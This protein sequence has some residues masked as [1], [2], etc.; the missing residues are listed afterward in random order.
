MYV[1]WNF[2]KDGR[3]QTGQKMKAITINW[4]RIKHVKPPVLT[5]D[6]DVAPYVVQAF[7]EMGI[8]QAYCPKRTI[9]VARLKSKVNVT[10]VKL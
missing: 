10:E 3:E 7:I 9:D 1:E 5:A 2:K 6:V 4:I 8:S